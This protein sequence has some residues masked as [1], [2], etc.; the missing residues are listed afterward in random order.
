MDPR[1][2]DVNTYVIH[3]RDGAVQHGRNGV[4]VIR[5]KAVSRAG[6]WDL[7]VESLFPVVNCEY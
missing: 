1:F 4:L 7:L 6:V 2:V 3:V 5:A